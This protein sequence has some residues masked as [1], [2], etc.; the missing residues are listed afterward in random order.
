MAQI[1]AL[2]MML[3][4]PRCSVD[5]SKSRTASTSPRTFIVVVYEIVLLTSANFSHSAENRNIEFGLLIRDS[6]LAVS[7][8]LTMGSKRGVCMKRLSVPVEN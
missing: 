2:L 3:I 8:E 7:I 4:H 6:G 5:Q 1:L